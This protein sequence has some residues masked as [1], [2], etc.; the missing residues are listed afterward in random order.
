MKRLK[1]LFSTNKIIMS[2]KLSSYLC[3]Y[4]HSRVGVFKKYIVAAL[5]NKDN[6]IFYLESTEGMVIPS[7]DQKNCELLRDAQI[8]TEDTKVSRNG[9]NI[10]RFFCLTETGK[11]MAEAIKAESPIIEE[12]E[13]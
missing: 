1:F 3:D 8:F 13:E 4:I 10:Y 7:S 12:N 5:E 2:E 6:C 11:K 9:H